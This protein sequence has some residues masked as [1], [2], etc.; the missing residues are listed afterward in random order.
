VA[1]GLL[2]G[3]VVVV[4]AVG[5]L[6]VGRMVRS[7]RIPPAPLGLAALGLPATL[8]GI[9]TA[10]AGGILLLD[11]LVL[12]GDGSGGSG[13]GGG[14]GAG[15]G[16]GGGGDGGGGGGGGGGAGGGQ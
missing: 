3:V 9:P 11:A 13:T 2:V 5:W 6:L 1:I 12:F 7:G 14:I 15:G 16:G 10:Y 4:T 8:F